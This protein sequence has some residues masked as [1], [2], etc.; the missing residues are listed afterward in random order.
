MVP[1]QTQVINENSWHS[2]L[3]RVSNF[4][5]NI[6][7]THGIKL[8]KFKLLKQQANLDLR[9]ERKNNVACLPSPHYSKFIRMEYFTRNDQAGGITGSQLWRMSDFEIVTSWS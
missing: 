9:K 7:K 1:R 5:L 2:V 3:N 6:C 4:L 8:L